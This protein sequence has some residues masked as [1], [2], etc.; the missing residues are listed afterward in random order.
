MIELAEEIWTENCFYADT[1]ANPPV[2]PTVCC[3]VSDPGYIL[4]VLLWGVVAE[5]VLSSYFQPKRP[6]FW[7]S[8][9]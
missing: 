6:N 4:L 2:S 3:A 8:E 9:W 7:A 5:Y 1:E